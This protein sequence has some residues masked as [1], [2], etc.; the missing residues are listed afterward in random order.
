[1]TGVG[2]HILDKW[3]GKPERG[4]SAGHLGGSYQSE[5]AEHAWN[6]WVM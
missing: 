5:G 4:K 1:M 2:R 6:I 3:L